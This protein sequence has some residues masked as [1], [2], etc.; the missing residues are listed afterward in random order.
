[1]GRTNNIIYGHDNT[2]SDKYAVN[3]LLSYFGFN[4]TGIKGEKGINFPVKKARRPYKKVH[5]VIPIKMAAD[6]V[7]SDSVVVF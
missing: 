1:M 4:N 6:E 3:A 5:L 2:G 7:S